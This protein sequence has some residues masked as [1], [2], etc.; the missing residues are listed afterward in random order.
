MLVMKFVTFNMVRVEEHVG[1]NGYNGGA[2]QVF[3]KMSKRILLCFWV[4]FNI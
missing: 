2:H 3:D 1:L 4:V